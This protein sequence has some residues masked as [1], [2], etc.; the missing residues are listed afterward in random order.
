MRRT[1]RCRERRKLVR[2]GRR[3]GRRRSRWRCPPR[4]WIRASTRP[5]ARASSCSRKATWWSAASAAAGAAAFTLRLAINSTSGVVS[6]AARLAE[7]PERHQ[8]DDSV[9]SPTALLAVVTVTD[10]DG[11]TAPARRSVSVQDDGPAGIVQGA[12]TVARRD[13]DRMPTTTPR[14]CAAGD[15]VR[16]TEPTGFAQDATLVTRSARTRRAGRRRSRWRVASRRW[17][18]ASTRPTAR[19]SSCSRKATWWSAASAGAAAAAFAVAIASQ[20]RGQRRPQ[21]PAR[22]CARQHN[23]ATSAIDLRRCWRW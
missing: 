13:R 17:I 5:R 7:A 19:A 23:L 15:P 8:P 1:R 20:R 10:G 14:R 22:P 6:G 4:G 9:R 21:R 3:A 12:A 16:P 18:P 11:D 2:R